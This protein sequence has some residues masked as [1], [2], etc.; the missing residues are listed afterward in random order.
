MTKPRPKHYFAAIPARALADRR[1][2][3]GRFLLLGAACLHACM[4]RGQGCWASAATLADLIGLDAGTIK[5]YLGD[6]VKWGY[7]QRQER[8]GKTHRTFYVGYDDPADSAVIKG[9]RPVISG[10]DGSKREQPTPVNSGNDGSPP[11]RHLETPNPSSL[12]MTQIEF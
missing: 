5:N 6:L 1:L 10:N 9:A 11:T 3:G 12:E 4:N 8:P 2:D 7:L